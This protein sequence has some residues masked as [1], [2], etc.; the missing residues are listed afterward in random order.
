MS[1]VTTL[2]G[3]KMVGGSECTCICWW[4]CSVYC[5]SSGVHD[6]A[7]R[8]G[9]WWGD[10]SRLQQLPV[11]AVLYAGSVCGGIWQRT[12]G[13]LSV[14]LSLMD[15]SFGLTALIQTRNLKTSLASYYHHPNTWQHDFSAK[16]CTLWTDGQLVSCPTIGLLKWGAEPLCL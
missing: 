4:G 6:A 12:G 5:I 9:R 15:F 11:I 2:S 10:H 14:L 7:E 16:C 8:E 1:T 13:Y 3:T